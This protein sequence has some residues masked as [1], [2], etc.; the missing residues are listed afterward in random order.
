MHWP[1]STMQPYL[2]QKQ[3]KPLATER[4]VFYYPK[5][6]RTH[7]RSEPPGDIRR[8]EMRMKGNS[9]T[10][11]KAGV[12]LQ[13]VAMTRRERR[14][15]RLR[16]FLTAR[17]ARLAARLA[18]LDYRV[19]NESGALRVPSSAQKWHRSSPHDRAGATYVVGISHIRFSR[20]II[21]YRWRRLVAEHT[22]ANT[23]E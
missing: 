21:H 19:S 8:E 9:G 1:N 10:G 3:G 17:E 23:D 20:P 14:Y 13:L 5:D 7:Q 4:E 2:G 15:R 11:T 22:A 16:G 18:R 12:D 6:G